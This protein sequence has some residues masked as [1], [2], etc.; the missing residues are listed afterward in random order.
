[1][2]G[3]KEGGSRKRRRRRERE[4]ERE[5]ISGVTGNCESPNM[6]AGNWTK[7]L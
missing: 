3:G 1:L 2:R 5:W 7:V 4:R 6:C